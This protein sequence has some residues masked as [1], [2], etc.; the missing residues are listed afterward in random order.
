M[1]KVI[2]VFASKLASLYASQ[3]RGLWMTCYLFPAPPLQVNGKSVV[4][5]QHSEVV[6]AIKAGGDETSMLVVDEETDDFFRRCH[7]LPTEEHLSGR[8]PRQGTCSSIAL[9]TSTS[10]RRCTLLV[11]YSPAS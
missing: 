6:A 3:L 10:R 4:G 5:L 7:V 2:V 8:R 11:L 9:E 1:D